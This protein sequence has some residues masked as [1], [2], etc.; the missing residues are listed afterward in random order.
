M[1]KNVGY[2]PINGK[3][4]DPATIIQSICSSDSN[5]HFI[6]SLKTNMETEGLADAVNTRDSPVLFDWLMGCFSYQGISDAI[7][8][9]FIAKHGNATYSGIEKVL[10]GR[11]SSCPKL[12]DFESFKDCGYKKSKAT[13]NNAELYN[14]C[15]VNTLNLRKGQL[16]QAAYSL[17]FF[18][19]DVCGGDLTG[20]IDDCLAAADLPGHPDRV[21]LMR[22]ALTSRLLSIFGIAQ[23]LINMAFADLL[24]G[25]DRKRARWI[26]V[27]GSMVAIDSL[28][29]NFL[30]R[31]GILYHYGSEH[32]T[33]AA[34]YGKKGCAK[35]LDDI[36]RQMDCSIIDKSYPVYFPR[37]IQH[38]IWSYCAESGSGICNGNEIDDAFRC[39]QQTCIIFKDCGRVALKPR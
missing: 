9:S 38:A 1:H 28:V 35:I 5:R 10:D 34:C 22:K 33:G 15:P 19:W 12:I 27:G 20:F 4:L 25:S 2:K 23:K 7:A 6:Q 29:H 14:S 36:A 16:N 21:A 11:V 3:R 8:D 13:C 18:I 26:E 32:K 24:I 17:Y 30:H 31:T 39:N 37:F